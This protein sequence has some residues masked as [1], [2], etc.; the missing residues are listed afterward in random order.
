MIV[1]FGLLF[2]LTL[3]GGPFDNPIIKM[4]LGAVGVKII[5]PGDLKGAASAVPDKGGIANFAMQ[6]P[7]ARKGS[8]SS[9]LP[10]E[11]KLKVVDEVQRQFALILD[12]CFYGPYGIPVYTPIISPCVTMMTMLQVMT[13]WQQVEV[14]RKQFEMEEYAQIAG[15][16]MNG[17]VV[18][19]N[20]NLRHRVDLGKWQDTNP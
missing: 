18:A 12:L 4:G 9:V 1:I 15:M 17:Y 5:S 2:C 13:A 14:F 8:E 6:E 20:L 16:A 19:R 7:M 3:G 10:S 11:L